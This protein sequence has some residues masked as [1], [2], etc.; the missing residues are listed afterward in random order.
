MA[1]GVY[2]GHQILKL[3]RGS[4]RG[5]LVSDREDERCSTAE[6]EEGGLQRTW[7][8]RLHCVRAHPHDNENRHGALPPRGH[9]FE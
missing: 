2:A 5:M 6:C 7:N 3:R 1:D 4:Y 8:N 9:Q